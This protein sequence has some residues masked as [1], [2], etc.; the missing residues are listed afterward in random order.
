MQVTLLAQCHELPA[1][2]I[3]KLRVWTRQHASVPQSTH[4]FHEARSRSM[5]CSGHQFHVRQALA[6]G[7]GKEDGQPRG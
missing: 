3:H 4:Q 1:S 2:K 7:R 5:L 6:R